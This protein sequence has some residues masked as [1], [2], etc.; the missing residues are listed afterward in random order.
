MLCRKTMEAWR[1]LDDCPTQRPFW[2]SHPHCLR[3]NWDD[4]RDGGASALAAQLG[5]RPMAER[6]HDPR[7]PGADYLQDHYFV[8]WLCPNCAENRAIARWFTRV[9]RG[10]FP[11]AAIV[12]PHER[13]ATT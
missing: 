4:D 13:A 9:V 12:R 2:C 3:C 1:G 10:R 7:Y 11:G 8:A 5:E 6:R